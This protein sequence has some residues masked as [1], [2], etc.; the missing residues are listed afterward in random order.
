[1]TASRQRMQVL[2]SDV[3]LMVRIIFL[4]LF[5]FFS[6]LP[7]RFHDTSSFTFR[8]IDRVRQQRQHAGLTTV[9][10]EE[11]AKFA[12]NRSIYGQKRDPGTFHARCFRLRRRFVV[13][14]DFGPSSDRN[15]IS[16]AGRQPRIYAPNGFILFTRDQRNKIDARRNWHAAAASPR[17][18]GKF[19]QRNRGP[20]S[21][22]SPPPPPSHPR[23]LQRERIF[24]FEHAHGKKPFRVA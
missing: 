7:T 23:P 1:M 9:R 6:S 16:A 4:S 15:T 24:Q 19:V 10:G 8:L 22:S 20:V 2:F 21:S 18:I 11:A 14:T 5:F 12:G 17:A 3:K 13:Y